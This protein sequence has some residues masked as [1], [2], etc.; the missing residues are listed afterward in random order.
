MFATLLGCFFYV[1]EEQVAARTAQGQAGLAARGWSL[2]EWIEN[3]LANA[4]PCQRDGTRLPHAAES[5]LSYAR[6]V[7]ADGDGWP[8]QVV[9]ETGTTRFQTDDELYALA[10]LTLPDMRP[11]LVAR[12]DEGTV[13]V[14]DEHVTAFTVEPLANGEERAHLLPRWRVRLTLEGH[15]PDGASLV[16]SGEPVV[17]TAAEVLP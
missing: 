5:S 16:W 8:D 2:L 6:T 17:H 13:R 4:V 9:T 14:L 3:E 1:I 10:L 11:A 15:D 7:D 12:G